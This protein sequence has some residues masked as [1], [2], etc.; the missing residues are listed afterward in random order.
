MG[1]GEAGGQQLC[2]LG[3]CCRIPR[4]DYIYSQFIKEMYY[5]LFIPQGKADTAALR[6]VPEGGIQSGDSHC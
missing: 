2:V 3:A 5:L 1:K 6:A 4:L